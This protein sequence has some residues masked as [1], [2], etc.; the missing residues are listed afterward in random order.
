MSVHV[1]VLSILVALAML[2]ACEYESV[3]YYP[4]ADMSIG[5]EVVEAP[6]SDASAPNADAGPEGEDDAGGQAPEEQLLTGPACNEDSDCA[7]ESCI[8]TALLEDLGASGIEIPGGLCS[9]LLCESDGDCGPKA[10]CIDGAPFGAGGFQICLSTCEGLMDCR[11]GEGWGCITPIAEQP[12]LSV[13]LP[14][15]VIVALECEQSGTCEE[16]SP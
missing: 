13:C 10:T 16:D 11:W 3:G 6:P 12:E 5:K 4:D 15:N 9:R 14:D 1:K 8:T 2:T 7:S